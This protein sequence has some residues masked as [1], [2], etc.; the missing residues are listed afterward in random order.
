MKNS[1]GRAIRGP[2]KG[3]ERRTPPPL[4]PWNLPPLI[5]RPIP[6]FPSFLPSSL[7]LFPSRPNFVRHLEEDRNV[8]SW[9]ERGGNERF[10]SE[11]RMARRKSISG[12]SMIVLLIPRATLSTR[13][14]CKLPVYDISY[15]VRMYVC[16]WIRA[17]GGHEKKGGWEGEGMGKKNR[18]HNPRHQSQFRAFCPD[19]I[20]ALAVILYN[21]KKYERIS[22]RGR[23]RERERILEDEFWKDVYRARSTRAPPILI[24]KSV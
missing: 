7:P 6:R 8:K 11:I 15:G 17:R 14:N 5:S 9:P 4:D 1:S 3:K 13:E 16:R 21:R 24:A 20:D 23:N 18:N 19:A 2:R 12:A 10:T 22:K